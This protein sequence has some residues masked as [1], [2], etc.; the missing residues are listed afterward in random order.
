[1]TVAFQTLPGEVA[2]EIAPVGVVDHS[3]IADRA[4]CVGMLE[5]GAA[6]SAA[7]AGAGTRL[8]QKHLKGAALPASPL[9]WGQGRSGKR[10]PHRYFACAAENNGQ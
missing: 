8:G 9:R 5:E 7:S 1:M 4:D 6:A 10:F 2:D 3:H